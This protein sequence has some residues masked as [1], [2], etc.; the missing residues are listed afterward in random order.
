MIVPATNGLETTEDKLRIAAGTLSE[1][2]NYEIAYHSGYRRIDGFVRYDGRPILGDLDVYRPSVE[3]VPGGPAY[4]LHHFTDWSSYRSWLYAVVEAKRVAVSS[5]GIEPTL[6]DSLTQRAEVYADTPTGIPNAWI[7][8]PQANFGA[9]DEDVI[10]ILIDSG[11]NTQFS[12]MVAYTQLRIKDSGLLPVAG[13]QITV[14]TSSWSAYV[15]GVSLIS[16]LAANG[17]AVADLWV[18]VST[19]DDIAGNQVI[20]KVSDSA[21]IGSVDFVRGYSSNGAL[22]AGGMSVSSQ[23]DEYSGVLIRSS[24]VGWELV[25]PSYEVRFTA[26]AQAPKPIFGSGVQVEGQV[27]TVSDPI[28]KLFILDLASGANWDKSGAAFLSA[29][30]NDDANYVEATLT[31][32]SSSTDWIYASGFGTELDPLD[33]PTGIEFEVIAEVVSGTMDVTI[34]N[35]YSLEAT[36]AGTAISTKQTYLIGGPNDTWGLASP[37]A[38]RA[39][40]EDYEKQWFIAFA[41]SGTSDPTVL[42]VYMIRRKIYGKQTVSESIVYFRDGANDYPARA[43]HVHKESGEW[44]DGD[45]TGI[46][47]VGRMENPA[48]VSGSA[49]IRSQPGGLGDL[50]ATTTGALDPVRLPSRKLMDDARSQFEFITSN[51]FA[52]ARLAAVYGV[53]GVGPAFTFN[54][55]YFFQIRTG[56]EADEPRHLARHK[57]RLV[58]GYGNGDA[59][60]SVATQP[61]LFDGV[62]GAFSVGFGQRITGLLPLGGEALGVWTINSTHAVQGTTADDVISQIISPTSGALEYSVRDIGIPVFVDFRGISTIASSDRYGDFDLGRLSKSIRSW[63][64]PKLQEP[65]KTCSGVVRAEVIRKKNQY[66]VWFSD[67]D[68]LT[69]TWLEDHIPRFTTQKWWLDA[70]ETQLNILAWASGVDQENVPVNF[71]SFEESSF[72]FR[73]EFT[74]T[75]DGQLIRAEVVFNPV[76]ANGPGNNL[77]VNTIHV[78]GVTDAETTLKSQVGTNYRMPAGYTAS[79]KF[80][81]DGSTPKSPTFTKLKHKSRGRDFA[82][83]IATKDNKPPHT[84]QVIEWPDLSDRRKEL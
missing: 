57:D 35:F 1:C 30:E 54:D 50:L 84:I 51:F 39:A 60:F 43:L 25:E 2:L 16:G 10:E 14:A 72:V 42:R 6:L 7:L 48:S 34:S 83:K 23:N 29:I 61:S 37:E 59:D 36:R 11:F 68:I 73:T 44:A 69:M 53:S 76:N 9:P 28:N 18:E 20:Q 77:R 80:G 33:E 78:H 45:A 46:L 3:V 71:A 40:I 75:F 66:R 22:A 31:G 12:S 74:N 47:T 5:R 52:S 24:D 82:L 81:V 67:G 65:D 21:T 41:A 4:G 17:D 8:E 58:L 62:L 27:S 56:R 64:L 32:A 79:T 63:L 55:N 19:A 13:E 15:R 70:D 49:Q 38:L 26:G